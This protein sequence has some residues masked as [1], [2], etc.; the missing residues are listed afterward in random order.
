MVKPM[1]HDRAA[2]ALLILL[3]CALFLA[4][5][6]CSLYRNDRCYI[7]DENF[8]LAENLFLESGSIDLVERQLKGLEWRR[9]EINETLYRLSKQ[10]EVVK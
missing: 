6:A 4:P 2:K 3:S 10:F 9:C 8:A 5:A 1:K 7:E